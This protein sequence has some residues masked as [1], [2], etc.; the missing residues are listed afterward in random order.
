MPLDENTTLIE[1]RK[2]KGEPLLPP[3]SILV[4]TPQDVELFLRRFASAAVKTH[5]VC[6]SQVYTIRC[7]G[8]VISLV[9]PV[10][11]A[12]QAV[13]V[14]EKLIALGVREVVAQGWCG[15]LQS[16][17]VIGDV[18]LPV[19]AVSE[20]GTSA[21]YPLTAAG[22]SPPTDL[23]RAL[24]KNL[25][26]AGLRLHGGAVWTTD[27][28]YRETVGKVL[29]YQR[30]GILAVEMETSALLTVARFRGISLAIALV[31]SDELSS[32][33]WVHGFRRS[34]FH[35]TR[36]KLVSVILETF[37]GRGI[38]AAFEARES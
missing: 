2:G 23:T 5:T 26:K 6:L 15:S 34:V 25:V 17:V 13:M 33:K 16:H 8:R 18:V 22:P 28:P 32:L 3:S 20:E 4:F 27:A 31:V 1:P 14:L 38:S 36:E 10:L 21:H 19:N 24:G 29:N 12:P 37:C 7:G 35:E 30:R 9:G 11:G